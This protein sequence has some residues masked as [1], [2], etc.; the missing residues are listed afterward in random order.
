M[1]RRPNDKSVICRINS[2][3][4]PSET[5]SSLTIGS[6]SS[7]RSMKPTALTKKWRQ[8]SIRWSSGKRSTRPKLHGCEAVRD[9]TSIKQI[10]SSLANVIAF[11]RDI[12]RAQVTI[13][14]LTVQ[15]AACRNEQ[16]LRIDSRLE[17]PLGLGKTP[18][19]ARLFQLARLSL[20]PNLGRDFESVLRWMSAMCAV[21]D[22]L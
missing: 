19:D 14:T 11:R 7:S 3:C 21:A 12:H 10:P 6:R 16:L 13:V 15:L 5:H 2:I 20:S 8:I 9:S 22:L 17:I 4:F 18:T 1:S